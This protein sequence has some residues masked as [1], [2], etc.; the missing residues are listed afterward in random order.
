MKTGRSP[1]TSPSPRWAS[2]WGCTKPKGWK[3]SSGRPCSLPWM[4]SQSAASAAV[5]SDEAYIEF[6]PAESITG[7]VDQYD[8]LVVLRTLSK[9]LAFV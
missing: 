8:N 9:A 6:A 7:L 1:A 5:I 3:T 4:V 2:N